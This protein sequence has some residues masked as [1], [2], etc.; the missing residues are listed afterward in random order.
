VIVFDE[1]FWEERYRSAAAVWSGRPNPQLVAEAAGLPPGKALDVGCGEGADALWL[2]ARGWQVTAVDFATTALERGAAHA[3]ALGAEVAGRIRWVH[4]DLDAW[5]PDE[6]R[7][8]LVSAQFLQLPAVQ[9]RAL[10]GRLAAT[11]AP[12]GALLVV[13]HDPRD[14]ETTAHRPP[15]PDLFFTAEEVAG[16]LGSDGWKVLVAEARPRI[17]DDG[18]GGEITVHDAVLHARRRP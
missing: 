11:V 18:D 14:L 5:A 17:A 8:H 9:R 15:A 7:F 10:F 6:E 2:A 3:Q 12:G 4:A 13:G 1:Q 16:S